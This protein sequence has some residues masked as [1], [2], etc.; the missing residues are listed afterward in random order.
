MQFSFE[1]HELRRW[2]SFSRIRTSSWT[3]MDHAYY[4]KDSVI[5]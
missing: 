4:R 5:L 2:Y 3:A 1:E